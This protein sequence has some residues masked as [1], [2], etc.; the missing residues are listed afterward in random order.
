[1]RDPR[2]CLS[3]GG[4]IRTGA[5]LDRIPGQFVPVLHDAVAR[6]R[7]AAP[8][9]SVYVYGS[10]AT[11]VATSPGSDVDLLTIGLHA[12][13]AAEIGAQLT[14][15]HGSVCRGV[16]IAAAKASDFAGDHDEAYGARVFLHHYCVHLAGSDFDRARSGFAGDRR[17][18]RGFNGD[19]GRH[20]AWWRRDLDRV[21]AADLG[22]RVG[23]KTLLAVAGLVSVHD[24]MW[25]TDREHA[26]TRW[27]QVHPDLADGLDELY[28]WAEAHQSASHRRLVERL[29]STVDVIVE[30]FR[31][32]IGLW[33]S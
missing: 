6:V 19:I 28:D 15:Q 21:A 10:V 14:R 22:R 1:V 33:Q 13:R 18:A 8:S 5:S 20:A 16:E 24:T 31:A 11:G 25:T 26:A 7:E 27:G 30:Q 9:A 2:E 29:D 17:A 12:D 32:D 3:A 23:R 4:A